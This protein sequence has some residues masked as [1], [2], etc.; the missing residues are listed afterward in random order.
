MNKLTAVVGQVGAGKSSLISAILGEMEK[1]EGF[2]GIQV[3][4]T[5]FFNSFHIY[6]YTTRTSKWLN[7]YCHRK[8]T[9][10]I[11]QSSS[12]TTIIRKGM[13]PTTFPPIGV[14]REFHYEIYFLSLWLYIREVNLCVCVW[15][16]CMC[17]DQSIWPDRQAQEAMN[18]NSI[19]FI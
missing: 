11:S 4:S 5:L 14:V 3:I 2:V 13:N 12:S 8:W 17:K 7:S 18:E 9:F 16:G 19:K 6:S 10:G 15:G 1:I